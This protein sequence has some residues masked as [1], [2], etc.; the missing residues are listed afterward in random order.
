[1]PQRNDTLYSD[2]DLL[3]RINYRWIAMP[4]LSMLVGMLFALQL[5]IGPYQNLII[6][7]YFVIYVI[8]M[9]YSGC[10]LYEK[11]RCPACQCQLNEV[12]G[13]Q[14]QGGVIGFRFTLPDVCPKCDTDLRQSFR[15]SVRSKLGSDS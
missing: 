13:P 3:R 2:I 5:P 9:I 11:L 15:L 14:E 1:M 4:F 7:V 10:V 6:V 8:L 12:K